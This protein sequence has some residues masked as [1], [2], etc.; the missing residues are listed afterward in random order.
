MVVTIMQVLNFQYKKN[1]LKKR[2]LPNNMIFF[3]PLFSSS[4]F[5]MCVPNS[6]SFF[7]WVGWGGRR[8]KFHLS[9]VIRVLYSASEFLFGGTRLLLWLAASTHFFSPFSF[10]T[11]KTQPPT[12]PPSSH[13]HHYQ[14]ILQLQIPCTD[15]HAWLC[16]CMCVCARDLW[17]FI[18]FT[19][20]D[21]H[22]YYYCVVGCEYDVSWMI[23][24]GWNQHPMLVPW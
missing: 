16:V 3:C 22:I 14:N 12:K 8:N 13:F 6:N 24:L 21:E 17:D 4:S 9:F 18:F 11:P 15:L 20:S 7:F 10:I 19:S 23:G 2:L 1:Y 5:C